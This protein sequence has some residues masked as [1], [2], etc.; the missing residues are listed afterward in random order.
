MR[1]PTDFVSTNP[2]RSKQGVPSYVRPSRMTQD[3][4]YLNICSNEPTKMDFYRT[5]PSR[6]ST[7]SS[8]V[9]IPSLATKPVR[10]DSGGIEPAPNS[11]PSG[12]TSQHRT[13]GSFNA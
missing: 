4:R 9:G 12:S 2:E 1:M 6:F 13:N 5:L 10:P 3:L 7:F 8:K 11:S